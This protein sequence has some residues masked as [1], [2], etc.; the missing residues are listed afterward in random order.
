MRTIRC[1][2]KYLRTD[3][4]RDFVGAMPMQL[5]LRI[6]D[7]AGRMAE[8][9]PTFVRV[10]ELAKC[11]VLLRVLEHARQV[12]SR[13]AAGSP[14]LKGARVVV[15]GGWTCHILACLWF[16][17]V[18]EAHQV[19]TA[20]PE[21]PEV[22]SN[23]IKLIAAPQTTQ[24]SCAMYWAVQTMT[25]AGF[26]DIP[27]VSGTERLV[28]MCALVLGVVAL[29]YALITLSV[30]VN[31]AQGDGVAF[32]QETD[33]MMAYMRQRGLPRELVHDASRW[34]AHRWELSKG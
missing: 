27:P 2:F 16:W 21:D 34:Y 9:G 22:C 20:Y 17:I 19:Q 24:Y 26:G 28:V 31:E 33:R 23:R 5:V 6:I 29:A 7:P 13:S 15:G 3:F 8:P 14:L 30:L 32:K 1:F 25:T 4:L 11:A 10:L 18:K 12:E